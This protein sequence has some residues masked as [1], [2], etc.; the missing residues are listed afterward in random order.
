MKKIL[1]ILLFLLLFVVL[2][3]CASSG[4]ATYKVEFA[5]NNG[6]PVEAVITDKIDEAPVST[7]ENYILDGWYLDQELNYKAVFPLSILGETILYAKW[8]SAYSITYRVDSVVYKIEYYAL[9]APV[10]PIDDPV[11]AGKRF[12]GWDTDIP[13][14]MPA[15]HITIGGSFISENY[16]IC[17][18]TADDV[19]YAS[20]V[21]DTY[22]TTDNGVAVEYPYISV[23]YGYT[24]YIADLAKVLP[25]R[26]G[27]DFDGWTYYD[28]EKHERVDFEAVGPWEFPQNMLLRPKWV[29]YGTQGLQFSKIPHDDRNVVMVSQYSGKF[30]RVIIPSEHE[31]KKVIKIAAG[32]FS[33]AT[34]IT[35]VTIPDS[36]TEIGENAFFGCINISEINIPQTV[37][38]IGKGAFAGCSSI[39]SITLPNGIV[40]V[41]ALTFAD[42]TSLRKVEFPRT[43]GFLR[44]D[45]QA[46]Q[47]CTTLFD[48]TLP[49]SLKTIG[50]YAFENCN[51]INSLQGIQYTQLY[52]IGDFAFRGCTSLDRVTLPNTLRSIGEEAFKDCQRLQQVGIQENLLSIGSRAF[53]NCTMLSRL[54][55]PS[56]VTSLG[57]ALFLNCKPLIYVAT[58]NETDWPSGWAVDW[59]LANA[60]TGAVHQPDQLQG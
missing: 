4:P 56:T 58:V 44:I 18:E 54:S 47:N 2:I 25:T 48:F 1:I 20:G 42:C 46:F 57:S 27:Y 6:T 60:E 38:S 22:K 32:A 9:G 31:G 13:A 40:S 51:S 37:T 53:E 35:S 33:G 29:Q 19:S 30:E 50:K 23:M 36:V 10:T 43:S 41:Q 21:Y 28:V 24:N 55:I 16:K 59:N 52:E 45:D 12:T 7:R 5:V 15:Q 14:Q 39:T 49:E 34:N 17:F 8:E 26:V 11:S 3:A